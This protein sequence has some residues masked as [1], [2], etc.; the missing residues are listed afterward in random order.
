MAWNAHAQAIEILE[1]LASKPMRFA[2]LKRRTKLAGATLE[3]R[4]SELMKAG[5]V[6]QE[7]HLAPTGRYYLK[8]KIAEKWKDVVLGAMMLKSEEAVE[9]IYIHAIKSLSDLSNEQ[10]ELAEKEFKKRFKI[11]QY[12]IERAFLEAVALA[13]TSV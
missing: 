6:E 9:R 11:I 5:W 7:P 12:H 13:R 1:A 2:E 10:K 3:R 8:Y 4:L